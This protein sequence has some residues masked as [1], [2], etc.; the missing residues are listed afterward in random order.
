[1]SRLVDVDDLMTAGEIAAL[2][3]VRPSAVSNWQ[4]RYPGFP[5]P[6][7]TWA[8]KGRTGRRAL[9]LKPEVLAWYKDRF[10]GLLAELNEG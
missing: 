3:G 4:R 1:V 5:A 7:R 6:V 2:I 10:A 9:W 8:D